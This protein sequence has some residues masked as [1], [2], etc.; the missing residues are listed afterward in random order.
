MEAIGA[1]ANVIAVVDLSVKVGLLCFQ[2]GK[3]VKNSATDI[4]QLREEV[5]NLQTVA[6]QVQALLKKPNAEKLTQSKSLD[7]VLQKSC[8]Q[9]KELSQR[10]DP[11]G[12][13][14]AM[15]KFGLRALKWPLQRDEVKG[16]VEGLRRYNE[17]ITQILQVHQTEVLHDVSETVKQTNQHLLNMHETAVLS[18]LPTAAGASYNSH[19]EQHNATCLPN[20]RV[21]LLQEI[22]EWASD[23]SSKA[24]FW[25][26]GMA[27]TGKSTISRTICGQFSE[28]HQLG[29]SFFFKRGEVD[30]GGL[31]RFVTTLAAQLADR[32]PDV[33][34]HIK[35]ALV[36]NPHI[37]EKATREQFDKLIKEPLMKTC[38]TSQRTCPLVFVVDALDECDRD[39][40]IKLVI[41]L[42]SDTND[43][44][45]SKLKLKCLMTSRPDLP[46]RLGFNA[47]KGK[48]QD[49]ILHEMPPSIIERDIATFLRHELDRIK[50]EYNTSVPAVRRL[51][52]DWP[53]NANIQA[54]VKMAIPLFIFASTTCRFLDDRRCGDPDMQLKEILDFQTESQAS[55]LDATYLPILNKLT[56]DLPARRQKDV[57]AKFQAIVGSIVILASPLSKAALAK[58]LDLPTQIINYQLDTLHSV[59]SIS[60]STEIPVRLLHLSF[61]DFLVDPEKDGNSPFW[62]NEKE[63]HGR[64]AANCLRV[65]GRCLR[66]DICNLVQPGVKRLSID[67]QVIQHHIPPEVQYACLYWVYHVQEGKVINNDNG[68]ILGFLRKHLLNWLEALSLVGRSSE[69]LKIIKSLEGTVRTT[70]RR[71]LSDF[72]QDAL[73]LVQANLATIDDVPLQIYT[74]VIVFTPKNSP[75]RQAFQAGIPKWITLLP[76]PE[77]NW[78]QCQQILEGHRSKIKSLALSLEGALAATSSD[79]K[80][81]RIWKFDDGTCVQELRGHR[82]AVDSVSFSPDGLLVVS[83]SQD[84]TAQL[85]SVQDGSCVQ[86]LRGHGKWVVAA[87]FSPDGT[88]V[89]TASH[90]HTARLWNTD[91]GTCV[92]EL[93]GHK[94][95][96]LSIIFSPDGTLAATSS[97]DKTVRIWKVKDGSCM[98]ELKGHKG[99][100]KSV[101]F[102]PDGTL[103]GSSSTDEV[104]RLWKIE[105]GICVQELKTIGK[106]MSPVCFS[107]DGK[108]VASGLNDGS[109]WI[110][111]TGDGTCLHKLKGHE[112]M[113]RSVVFSHDGTILA[114]CSNDGTVRL[115]RSDDGACLQELKGHK[116]PVTSV[117]FSPDDTILASSS[118]DDTVRI[119]K[120]DRNAQVQE[121]KG[122]RD[123][124]DHVTFSPDGTL[125]ASASTEGTVMLWKTN[126]G[127][128][129]RKLQGC[130]SWLG[131]LVFS[132]D[133]KLVAFSS[134]EGYVMI[135]KSDDGAC[136]PQLRGN[137]NW[138]GSMDFSPN[139][140][141]LATVSGDHVVQLWKIEDG[142]CIHELK[143]HEGFINSIVFSPD[144]MFLASVSNDKTARLWNTGDGTCLNVLEGH[145]NEVMSV[146]F[147]PDGTL[148]ASGSRDN[149][150]RLWK[151]AD[152]SC[153]QE[154]KGQIGSVGSMVFSLDGA[155]LATVSITSGIWLWRTGDGACIQQF[156]DISTSEIKLDSTGSFLLTDRGSIAI[157][158]FVSSEQKGIQPYSKNL[159]GVGISED[160]CWLWWKG[161]PILWLPAPFRGNCSK[162]CDLSVALGCSSGR[163]VIMRFGDLK[164]LK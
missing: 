164:F 104:I 81:I 44:A 115:W 143:G 41:D 4:N 25:L 64:M 148:M 1:A 134:D 63:T 89:A 122:H 18:T 62:V 5:T 70:G 156:Q 114:S 51:P 82:A 35:T 38:A 22:K 106:S 109:V 59:L 12:V 74:S 7:D 116:A 162:I 97:N 153:V 3:D 78:D 161:M 32:Q 30:R 13:R 158:D 113:A 55:Q 14:K 92:H 100:V 126:D 91:D 163:V 123:E 84:N 138:V 119:W 93:K 61:R 28:S 101:A 149:T 17:I 124:V 94:S 75:V 2:Y 42:F 19:D 65:M 141:L 57:I 118:N 121:T 159:D 6:E 83:A 20:T 154:L 69:S 45:L 105:D 60:E 98:H 40:D 130:E 107:P 16:L 128:C 142:T 87:I 79:D 95:P 150:A 54:L 37:S 111:R 145:T 157:Q 131:S 108:L 120:T 147:S 23:P 66:T 140:T 132:P 26:N 110:W 50:T 99:V 10:L 43:M 85:W 73:R 152:G 112:S 56:K 88:L 29:A 52:S 36:G 58:L 96:I 102:S 21:D 49:L 9:L 139:S 146:V 11:K 80:T 31:S 24:L 129:V 77:D 90:D 47:V 34:E 151:C 127:T 15:R 53:G 48:F 72:V 27:G 39:E 144:G 8:A 86:E 68:K 67:P 125:L 133:G 76:E 136:L 71:E 137:N 33:T 117:V 103:L 160:G 135:W 46:I 155:L